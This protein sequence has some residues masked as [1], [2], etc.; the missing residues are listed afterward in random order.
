[1]NRHEAIEALDRLRG[2]EKGWDSYNA[3][4]P[5]DGALYYAGAYLQRANL[6]PDRVAP[7]ATAGSVAASYYREKRKVY[8][9]FYNDGRVGALY[10]DL[11]VGPDGIEITV[12]DGLDEK[13]FPGF[14]ERLQD[15]LSGKTVPKITWTEQEIQD[16]QE[17]F[18]VPEATV[19]KWIAEGFTRKQ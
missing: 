15:Y 18:N 3:I 12:Y 2:L 9:E 7:S 13:T 17:A 6:I 10:S 14:E 4:P 11:A 16:L 5:G 19:R 8:L 1:M